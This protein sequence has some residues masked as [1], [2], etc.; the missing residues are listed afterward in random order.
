[1]LALTQN[2]RLRPSKIRVLTTQNPSLGSVEPPC[3]SPI[4]DRTSLAIFDLPGL[5]GTRARAVSVSAPR[6][7]FGRRDLLVGAESLVPASFLA[8]NRALEQF[9]AHS[10]R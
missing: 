6:S 7:L 3:C 4:P 8:K 2:P 1:M 5:S 10:D 9:H